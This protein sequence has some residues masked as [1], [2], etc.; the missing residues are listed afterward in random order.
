M[1]RRLLA[2]ELVTLLLVLAGIVGSVACILETYRRAKREAT[3]HQ[4]AAEEPSPPTIVDHPFQAPAPRP[5]DMTPSVLEPI[6]SAIDDSRAKRLALQSAENRLAIQLAASQSAIQSVLERNQSLIDR[7]KQLELATKAA[8]ESVDRLA[9]QRQRLAAEIDSARS[10]R[11]IAE[12]R[13]AGSLSVLPSKTPNGS[14]RRPIPIECVDGRAIVRPNGPSFAMIDLVG[15]RGNAPNLIGR[16]VLEI[17]SRVPGARSPDGSPAV[18]FILFL[19]RPDGI[20]AYYDARASLEPLGIAFGYELVDQDTPLD[21]PDL[22]NPAEWSEIPAPFS[23]KPKAPALLATPFPPRGEPQPY[24]RDRRR[25]P[26][27][28]PWPGNPNAPEIAGM[29]RGGGFQATPPTQAQGVANP[30]ETDDSLPFPPPARLAGG[31]ASQTRGAD[32]L[33]VDRPRPLGGN[34]PIPP[35]PRGTATAGTPSTEGARIAQDAPGDRGAPGSSPSFGSPETGRPT[36]SHDPTAD[37]ADRRFSPALEP[38]PGLSTPTANGP[39]QASS[40]NTLAD[41][42]DTNQPGG[43]ASSADNASQNPPSPERTARAAG[44][45]SSA[46]N[47]STSSVGERDSAD[48]NSPEST[49]HDAKRGASSNAPS[50]TSAGAGAPGLG[51]GE[52]SQRAIRRPNTDGGSR[53][54][55]F[56]ITCDR[57]GV[58]LRPSFGRIELATLEKNGRAI[59]DWL[60]AAYHRAWSENANVGFR[61]KILV[62]VEPGGE[63]A[64]RAVRRQLLLA[65][66]EWPTTTIY[67]Q[68]ARFDQATDRKPSL[69]RDGW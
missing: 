43:R 37:P 68:N 25:D 55:E 16:A 21:F 45:P 62:V 44:R 52:P 65:G 54:I 38:P 5:I 64:A 6:Q 63:A 7:T 46:T 60:R 10:E 58:T 8:A 11:T 39:L 12:R 17:A 15:A 33:G 23:A 53:S 27:E 41:S 42:R 57:S 36:G 66:V 61:P 20:R 14:W 26:A 22:E 50:P 13:A 56:A 32:A 4:T 49:N 1:R 18:P 67:G 40:P 24:D 19:V 30:T 2:Y 28:T 35:H 59:P 9:R 48:E 69:S 51:D 47:P 31:F 3:Q 29:T 34:S